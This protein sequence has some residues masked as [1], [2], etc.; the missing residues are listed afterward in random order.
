MTSPQVFTAPAFLDGFTCR[1]IQ[2]A[3]DAGITEPAE[4]L[5]RGIERDDDVRRASSVEIGARLTDDVE[6]RL[7]ALRDTI[8]AYFGLELTGRE[9]ASFLRYDEGGF[10]K[11]HRDRGDLPE[12]PG[13]ARRQVAVAVFLNS[14]RAV[15]RRGDF[16]GGALE[17]DTG[18][19]PIR[20]EP[21]RGLLVAFP[22]DLLHEVLT[23]TEGTRDTI[24]DWYY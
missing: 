21:V 22:A 4:I 3:M 14:S 6:R 8:G 9:G 13:A 10:Y 1:R 17:V 23:V 18:G 19:E 5:E 16:S 20:V 12:W 7:D 11:P 15:D 2:R 24:V